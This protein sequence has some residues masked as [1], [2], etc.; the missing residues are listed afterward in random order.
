MG[1]HTRPHAMSLSKRYFFVC[2]FYFFRYFTP[3]EYCIHM[4]PGDC[5]LVVVERL[6]WTCDPKSDTVWSYAP[7]RV[8]HGG[9][10][11]GEVS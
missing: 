3:L 7:G 4:S 10:V 11:K 5:H 6:A 2:F 9:K 1:N 8:T